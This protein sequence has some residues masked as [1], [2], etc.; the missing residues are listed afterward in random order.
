MTIEKA[1]K[2]L[3]EHLEIL[4][5]N[6]MPETHQAT[7]LGIEALKVIQRERKYASLYADGL[8]PGETTTD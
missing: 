2:T 8:L 4:R 6:D 7:R 3:T 1:I 5:A